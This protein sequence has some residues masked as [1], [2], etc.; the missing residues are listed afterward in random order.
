MKSARNFAEV[1]AA[2]ENDKEE[3]PNEGK[4]SHLIR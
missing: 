2:Q 1:E 3:Q 4:N